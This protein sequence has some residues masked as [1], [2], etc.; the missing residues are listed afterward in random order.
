VHER[1]A[2]RAHEGGVVGV[3]ADLELLVVGPA[4]QCGDDGAVEAEGVEV[5]AGLRDVV[6]GWAVVP[7]VGDAVVDVLRL[8]DPVGVAALPVR[9]EE[10]RIGVG[11]LPGALVIPPRPRLG[12]HRQFGVAVHERLEDDGFEAGS[13]FLVGVLGAFGDAPEFAVP[14]GEVALELAQA[15][16]RRDLRTTDAT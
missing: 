1:G 15:Q 16:H 12:V 4:E 6:G 11:D 13:P 9:L 7:F 3:G 10:Q 5:P 14:Q 8:D 2:D